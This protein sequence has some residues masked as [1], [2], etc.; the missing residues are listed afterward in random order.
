MGAKI[1]GKVGTDIANGVFPN[2]YP[3][4]ISY[5]LNHSAIVIPGPKS[6]YHVVS[7]SHKRWYIFRVKE[8]ITFLE[9]TFGKADKQWQGANPADF[10]GM[11]GIIV[12]QGQGW[13]DASGHVTL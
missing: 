8:M 2:A 11:Q 7:G 12:I 6:G 10:D 1:G 9:R 4:R 3:I 5:V 13:S